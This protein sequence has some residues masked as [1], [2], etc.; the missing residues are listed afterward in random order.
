MKNER[1]ERKRAHGNIDRRGYL[2]KKEVRLLGCE[3]FVHG[4]LHLSLTSKSTGVLR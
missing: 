2:K 4:G 3:Q 1:T